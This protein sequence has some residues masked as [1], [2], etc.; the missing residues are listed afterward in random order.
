[1]DPST[2]KLSPFKGNGGGRRGSK[3]TKLESIHS[4]LVH[5]TQ[6]AQVNLQYTEV[7]CLS[8]YG[9]LLT[10]PPQHPPPP[11]SLYHVVNSV[12]SL[13]KLRSWAS[14]S[15]STCAAFMAC[16]VSSDLA[17]RHASRAC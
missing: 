4:T 8:K 7:G 5:P 13:A 17:F 14:R 1:M 12:R 3:E 11:L 9:L 2:R 6:V 16:F 15:N 10:Y